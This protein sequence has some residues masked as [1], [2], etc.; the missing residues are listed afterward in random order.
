MNLAWQFV[1]KNGYNMSE[2]LKV[3]WRNIKLKTQMLSGIAHF[4][5]VKVDGSIRE[6]HSLRALPAPAMLPDQKSSLLRD[7][8][9][10]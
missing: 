9:A 4:R 10:V 6:A 1:R 5:F 3:A 7:S 8:F 2:A